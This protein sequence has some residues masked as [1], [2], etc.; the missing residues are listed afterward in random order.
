MKARKVEHYRAALDKV[1]Q[2][3]SLI[4]WPLV[5]EGFIKK[6]IAEAD[7]RPK[8]NVLTFNA[9]RALGRTVKRGEHGVRVC[10][11]RTFERLKRDS[12]TGEDTVETVK[13]PWFSTV[14]HIS[15]T[16]AWGNAIA[17]QNGQGVAA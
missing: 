10:T 15:Q 4:N 13:T 16:E 7:I 12:V 6:G 8:E 14:F 3:Q 11:F 17:G 1:F 9:W 5:I 2:S